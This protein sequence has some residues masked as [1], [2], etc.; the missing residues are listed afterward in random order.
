MRK[1]P[2]LLC[3]CHRQRITSDYEIIYRQMTT[4]SNTS[5]SNLKF[6]KYTF[7]KY[8]TFTVTNECASAASNDCSPNARCIDRP[9][10]TITNTVISITDSISGYTCRCMEEFVDLSPEGGKRPGRVCEKRKLIFDIVKYG[11]AYYSDQSRDNQR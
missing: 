4:Y 1:S 10:G 2:T 5:Y 8:S 6:T 7:L 3:P 11:S 9:A